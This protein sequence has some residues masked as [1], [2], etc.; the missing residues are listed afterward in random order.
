VSPSWQKCR[1]YLSRARRIADPFD[2]S[3]NVARS[4]KRDGRLPLTLSLTHT[5]S[6]P[7]PWLYLGSV[8]LA[9]SLCCPGP[10]SL[11]ASFSAHL[12]LLLYLVDALQDGIS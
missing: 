4:V 10:L 8:R 12:E 9:W 5:P 3:H 1:G 6:P 2:L 7:P 11:A